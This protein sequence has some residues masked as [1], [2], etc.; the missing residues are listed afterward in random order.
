MMQEDFNQKEVISKYLKN[1]LSGTRL[2]MSQVAK[3]WGVSTALLSQIKNKKKVPGLEF[4]LRILREANADLKVREDWAKKETGDNGEV[5]KL[6]YD[7]ERCRNEI[8]LN[9]KIAQQ[10]QSDHLMADIFMDISYMNESGLGVQ[11]IIRE[12]GKLGI[13]KANKLCELNLVELSESKYR[14]L[15]FGK[16]HFLTP[17]T[18]FEFVGDILK[19]QAKKI[20]TGDFRGEFNFEL[21]DVPEEIYKELKEMH[22]D[23]VKE[24]IEKIQKYQKP[25][26]KGG[27]RVIVQMLTSALKCILFISLFSAFS[28]E[29]I[30]AGDEGNGLGGG[31]SGVIRSINIEDIYK[32][33]TNQMIFQGAKYP[34]VSQL[35]KYVEEK[36]EASYEKWA[37]RSKAFDSREDARDFAVSA[38]NIIVNW[39]I[40]DDRIQRKMFHRMPSKCIWSSRIIADL[41]NDLIKPVGFDI[42]KYYSPDGREQFKAESNFF[43]PCIKKKD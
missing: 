11:T 35:K 27:R 38:N 33:S 28:S 31:A 39:R 15:N 10:L 21:N 5:A 12:Y 20:E 37:F 41:D 8:H 16:P 34:Y 26:L 32:G 36:Q 25:N 14:K 24:V 42:K 29:V 13:K 4:G 1:Y 30:F 19:V 6:Q 43:V 22:K 3:K 18:S 40:T 17:R 23:Y 2:S 9:E 7:I